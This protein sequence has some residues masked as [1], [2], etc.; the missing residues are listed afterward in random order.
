M[1]N[2]QQLTVEMQPHSVRSNFVLLEQIED[3]SLVERVADDP[4]TLVGTL[5]GN[6]GSRVVGSM[7]L[8]G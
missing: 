8:K 3:G 1:I 5:R 6:K 7:L 2:G 4:R